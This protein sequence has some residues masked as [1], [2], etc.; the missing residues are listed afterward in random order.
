M[1]KEH[2]METGYLMGKMAEDEIARMMDYTDRV[3]F[4]IHRQQSA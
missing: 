2:H 3:V 1:L 4:F